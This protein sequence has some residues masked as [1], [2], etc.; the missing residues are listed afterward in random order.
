MSQPDA[1][2]RSQLARIAARLRHDTEDVRHTVLDVGDD[3]MTALAER[4][5]LPA[6]LQA[7]IGDLMAELKAV[8]PRFSSHR[9]SSVLFDREGHWTAG[10]NRAQQLMQRMIAVCRAVDR[11]GGDVANRQT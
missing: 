8:Q 11:I 3:F 1:E 2:T 5:Y 9:N 7:E 4:T 6:S 10:R